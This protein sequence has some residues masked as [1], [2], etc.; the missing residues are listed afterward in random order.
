MNISILAFSMH[1]ACP[2][3]R[4]DMAARLRNACAV[5]VSQEYTLPRAPRFVEVHFKQWGSSVEAIN[6]DAVPDL[7][8]YNVV[9]I[10]ETRLED[11]RIVDENDARAVA[12]MLVIAQK[13]AAFRQNHGGSGAGDGANL[14]AAAPSL[15]FVVSAIRL[16]S[17]PVLRATANNNNASVSVVQCNELE[18]GALAQVRRGQRAHAC[19]ARAGGCAGVFD[20]FDLRGCA[21]AGS[22]EPGPVDGV[23]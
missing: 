19:Q 6:F 22:V 5:L 16:S 21:C 12:A 2:L 11:G 10:L 1:T 9:V 13:H 7:G 14:G 23:P 18:S 4:T 15:H 3:G 17:L 20:F 8:A